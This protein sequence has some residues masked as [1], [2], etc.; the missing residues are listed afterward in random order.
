MAWTNLINA[1]FLPGRPVLGS[2]GVALRDN[3]IA[4][5]EGAP[6]APRIWGRAAKPISEMPVVAI[7]ASPPTHRL[8]YGLGGDTSSSDME[9]SASSGEQTVRENTIQNFTG[10]VLL[11]FSQSASG[12]SGSWWRARIYK[13]DVLVVTWDRY[14]DQSPTLRTVEISVVPGDVI[15]WTSQRQAVNPIGYFRNPGLFASEA[16]RTANLYILESEVSE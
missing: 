13:N 5:A 1:I 8:T 4:L 14:W 9:I 10:S 11:S 12:S 15:K 16:Y 7:S 2:I 3:P 6:G